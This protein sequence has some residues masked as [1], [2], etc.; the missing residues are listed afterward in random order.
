MQTGYPYRPA[1]LEVFGMLSR[2]PVTADLL[3]NTRK[4]AL[5]PAMHRKTG[6]DLLIANEP[7]S[8]V[9]HHDA[10]SGALGLVDSANNMNLLSGTVAR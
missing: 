5:V 3:R 6:K 1:F 9:D 10:D 4:Y 7:A 2:L 8:V